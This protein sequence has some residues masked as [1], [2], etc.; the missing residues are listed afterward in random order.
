MQESKVYQS[1]IQST[2]QASIQDSNNFECFLNREPWPESSSGQFRII[3]RTVNRDLTR[4][5]ANFESYPE[6]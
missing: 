1:R 5:L 2:V 6:S 3:S 4:V